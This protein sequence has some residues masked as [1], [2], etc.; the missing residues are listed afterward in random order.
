MKQIKDGITVN[1][2][3]KDMPIGK[4]FPGKV[5]NILNNIVYNSIIQTII[6]FFYHTHFSYLSEFDLIVLAIIKNLEHLEQVL[7]LAYLGVAH[8]LIPVREPDII[9]FHP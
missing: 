5:I 2:H 6:F 8:T 7:I 3:R 1:R 4:L 9:L